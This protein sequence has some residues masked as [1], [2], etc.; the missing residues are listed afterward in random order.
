M[1]TDQR[2]MERARYLIRSLMQ[3]RGLTWGVFGRQE[4]TAQRFLDGE[5]ISSASLAKLRTS[6][7]L[8][9]LTFF[10]LGEDPAKAAALDN[11]RDVVEI[12]G[13]LLPARRAGSTRKAVARNSKV[14]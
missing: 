7:G 5:N 2:E 10:F 9:A 14:G 12:I 3:A 1:R 6:L 4:R 11:E 13:A 8:N